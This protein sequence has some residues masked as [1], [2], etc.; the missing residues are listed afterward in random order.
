MY[1]PSGLRLVPPSARE[2]AP[3]DSKNIGA[4]KTITGQ[5]VKGPACGC[6]ACN[7]QAK[8]LFFLFGMPLNFFGSLLRSPRNLKRMDFFCCVSWGRVSTCAPLVRVFLLLLLILVLRSALIA[9]FLAI[10]RLYVHQT[11]RIHLHLLSFCCYL[12]LSHVLSF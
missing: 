12:H 11:G 2:E 7:G 3:K 1:S 9:E 8:S 4:S 10:F 5:G 6:Y